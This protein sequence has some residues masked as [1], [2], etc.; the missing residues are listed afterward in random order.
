MLA[1]RMLQLGSIDCAIVVSGEYITHLTQTAQ[2]EIQND[3]DPRL[4]CLTLGDAGAA[5]ALT[6]GGDRRSG[7][8][9]ID[10][11]T[12]GRHAELCIAKLGE[13]RRP[14]M[15][16]DLMG[17]SAATTGE[18]MKH[19]PA[20]A[21]RHGWGLHDVRHIIPHQ[22]SDTMMNNG[23]FAVKD[24]S[25]LEE[26]NVVSN[27]AERGNTATTTHSVAVWDQVKQGT[28]RAGENVLF[29]IM[30][31][32]MT[33]G[34]ALYTFDDLPDRVR[35]SAAKSEIPH[36]RSSAAARMRHVRR[37]PRMVIA[38]VGIAADA[39]DVGAAIDAGT[40]AAER[41]LS[42]AGYQP[43]DVG[44][45][46]YTGIYREE[47]LSE[48]A[49]AAIIAGR[50]KLDGTAAGEAKPSRA[51][52]LL[53]G[54][55][56]TLQACYV[57]QQAMHDDPARAAMIVAAEVENNAAFPEPRRYGLVEGGSA[58]LL[59]RSPDGKAGFGGFVCRTFPEHLGKLETHTAVDERH[60]YLQ[61]QRHPDLEAIY[62]AAAKAVVDQLLCDE[63]LKLADVRHIF[64]PQISSNFI[65]RL[66]ESLAVPR[67]VMVDVTR[68]G[69]DLFT[70]SLPHAWQHAQRSGRTITGDLGILIAVGSGVQ[71]VAAVYYF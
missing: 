14:I 21:M 20:T 13:N 45:L 29:G 30:G 36:R 47:Y 58:L 22:V 63:G 31:S 70:S 51:F 24:L 18:V 38:G 48:P 1:D 60:G 61:I 35:A 40:R 49:V 62:V 59:Q 23:T 19:W 42:A 26:I 56:G 37:V 12:L 9:A 3:F 50:L 67:S 11:Y 39:G 34:A 71:A 25:V 69:G 53:N 68:N 28:I 52:D 65:T 5:I 55:V 32:G 54:G 57:A 2:R 15:L 64:A 41:C 66:A 43:S 46:V 4:P 8:H 16:T 7:F 10:L 33:I 44:L 27:I 6:R 17:M